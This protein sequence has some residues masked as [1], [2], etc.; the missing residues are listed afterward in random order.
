MKKLAIILIGIFLTLTTIGQSHIF[1][2]VE[3]NIW[4][5]DAWGRWVQ[6]TTNIEIKTESS[7]IYKISFY[8]GKEIFPET[9]FTVIFDRK[10]GTGFVYIGEVGISL[11]KIQTDIE[12]SKMCKGYG[13]L[14][15]IS[16]RG[17]ILGFK[18]YN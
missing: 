12:L 9:V 18:L 15:V 13:G 17:N 4:R 7:G 8:R 6:G 5:N 2:K 14:L 3:E 10:E 11:L 16:L 1:K